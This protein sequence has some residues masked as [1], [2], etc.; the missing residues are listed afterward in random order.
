MTTIT[1]DEDFEILTKN[2]VPYVEVEWDTPPSTPK[3]LQVDYHEQENLK[4][5]SEA[6]KKVLA[7]KADSVTNSPKRNRRVHT[8]F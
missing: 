6:I 8:G 1:T 7:P 3:N 2:D 5:L 4:Q